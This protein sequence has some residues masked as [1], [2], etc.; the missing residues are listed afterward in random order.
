MKNLKSCQWLA[1][2]LNKVHVLDAGI[3]KPG[4][5]KP[6]SPTAI[7]A[8]A[9]RFDISGALTNP[10]GILPNTMCDSAQF[11][12]AMRQ[13]GINLHDTVVVYDDMSLFSAPRAWWMLKSMG[14][15]QVYVLD[16]GLPHWLALGLPT[17]PSY[18]IT[19]QV[20]NFVAKAQP[21]YFIDSQQVLQSINDKSICL[22][23]ARSAKRFSGEDP[24]PRCNMRSG[25]IPNSKNLPY[26][27]ILNEQGLVKPVDALQALFTECGITNQALQF[28][29]GSG[30]T[31][32]ILAM[33][34]D[35][36]GYA[37]LSVYDGSWSE[38]GQP[39]NLPVEIGAN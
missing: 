37:Q 33:A 38:W 17:A 20:G 16:G 8:G 23:D 15:E 34:A 28:S 13:L 32:C 25:H 7:I 2:H 5:N 6:Y 29:C 30:V 9:K 31:A 27:Q 39:S 22:L 21:N 11:Q 12:A 14:F 18:A 35:E 3:V 10:K 19:T 26:Q 36:C 1:Q 4:V 24:E